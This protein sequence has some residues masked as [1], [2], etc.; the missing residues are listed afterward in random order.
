MRHEDIVVLFLDAN[1]IIVR[2]HSFKE[3]SKTF[4]H[5]DEHKGKQR[6]SLMSTSH[7]REGSRWRS[8]DYDGKERIHWVHVIP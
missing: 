1:Q 8:T 3:S 5:Q 7:G 4:N 2:K 6:V